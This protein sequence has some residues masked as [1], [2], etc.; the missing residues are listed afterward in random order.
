M[1]SSGREADL[2]RVAVEPHLGLL[3][4]Q[5]LAGRDAQLPFDQIEAGD[6][7]GH[8]VF[9]LQAGV[10]LHEVEADR[11]GQ[12]GIPSCRRR[13]SRSAWVASTAAAPMRA[14][15][16]ASTAGEGASSIDLL[17][18]PLHRA[19]AL[20][21]VDHVAVAVGRR[22]GSR[23]GGPSTHRAFEDQLA[24]AEGPPRPRSAP[25]RGP[26]AARRRPRPAACRAAAAGR[27]LHHHREADVRGRVH[28]G[29]VAL[30]LA[31]VAGSARASSAADHEPLGLRLVAHRAD[32]R[33]RRGR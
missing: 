29:S 32:R 14:R 3:D 9:Y 8:R 25:R 30:V 22:S 11:P 23:R 7:L 4:R 13:C 31:L 33:A 5:R 26:A 21:E 15:R 19:V 2:D 16:A 12:A 1:A 17:V 24:G 20:A 27:G 28:E 6:R 10:H 18:A